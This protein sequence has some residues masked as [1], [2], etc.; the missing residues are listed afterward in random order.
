L[1]QGVPEEK[2][3]SGDMNVRLVSIPAPLTVLQGIEIEPDETAVPDFR[4]MT[5]REVVKKSK[6]RG[7]EVRV[8]GSGWAIAQKPAAGM[9]APEDRLCTVTFGMGS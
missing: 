8:I 6:E 7:I 9:P 4:G 5:I 2:T 1:P 3:V